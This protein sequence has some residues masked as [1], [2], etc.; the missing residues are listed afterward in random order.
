MRLRHS[1]KPGNPLIADFAN[2]VE[3]IRLAG[4]PEALA[5]KAGLVP[6]PWQLRVLRSVAAMLLICCTRQA[7]KSTVVALVIIAEL[8]L[9]NRTVVIVAP[10]E[11]QA[12]ELYRKVLGFWR[13]LGKPIGHVVVNRTSLEL[14]N[15]SRLLVLP[16]KGDTI[17]GVSSVNLLVTEEASL[18]ADELMNAVAPMLAVSGGRVLAPGTPRGKR[19]W[20]YNRWIEKPEDDP[21]VER[22]EVKAT[23]IPRIPAA[24]LKREERTNPL[25]PAE[26]MCVF[27]DDE[28]QAFRTEDI[29]RAQIEGMETWDWILG[30][31][32]A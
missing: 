17:R 7:G 24:F 6:D 2:G 23:D 10:S 15:E 8:L 9:P 32:I 30:E 20:W 25:Y 29:E 16:G 18:V 21:D 22:I 5:A 19:G 13:R 26:Y 28:R 4:N 11:R 27:M 3:A 12:K 31:K 14:V 1:P